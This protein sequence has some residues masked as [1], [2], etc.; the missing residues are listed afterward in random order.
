MAVQGKMV[1]HQRK[2]SKGLYYLNV[3]FKML[4][5]KEQWNLF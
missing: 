1:D 5:Y 4:L 3:D 2:K